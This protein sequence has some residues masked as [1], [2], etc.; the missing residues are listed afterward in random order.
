MT[1]C[2]QASAGEQ[3]E[4]DEE[5]DEAEYSSSSES[6]SEDLSSDVSEDEALAFAKAARK[7]RRRDE[8]EEIRNAGCAIDKNH[9]ATLNDEAQKSYIAQQKQKRKL[10]LQKK[11]RAEARD[12]AKEAF[13]ITL[14]PRLFSELKSIGVEKILEQGKEYASKQLV[15][16]RMRELFN[17]HGYIPRVKTTS[18][19]KL[20]FAIYG[21]D[22]DNSGTIAKRMKNGGWQVPQNTTEMKYIKFPE[23][24]P[25]LE[26]G[27]K[28]CPYTGKQLGCIIMK[29]MEA[30]YAQISSKMPSGKELRGAI[31]PYLNPCYAALVDEAVHGDDDH[32]KPIVSS[33]LFEEAKA[34]A[35]I[36]LNKRLRK[37]AMSIVTPG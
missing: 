37:T 17:F 12:E 21:C 11:R 5:Q 3:L 32:T 35:S 31:H 9:L 18:A 20:H 26:R 6:S 13:N 19:Y 2:N 28:I 25:L 14:T 16:L 29:K 1:N 22:D 27:T 10:F 36:F 4:G 23:T 15:D 30:V 7:K 34:V 24:R 8:R 33:S